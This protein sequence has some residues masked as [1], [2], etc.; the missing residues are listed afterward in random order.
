MEIKNIKQHD[1]F[2]GVDWNKYWNKEI[3]PPFVPE[4]SG[5]MDLKYFDK[6]FTDEPVNNER[7]TVMSRSR[8]NE[9]QGFTFVTQSIAREMKTFT[10]DNEE[11]IEEEISKQDV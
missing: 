10:N 11:Q 8:S 6:M 1:F 7:P 2:K 3:P 5:E 9:Y 4:L